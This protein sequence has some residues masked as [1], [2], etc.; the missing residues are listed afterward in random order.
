[1]SQ[2]ETLYKTR[3]PDRAQ[4]EF[5]EVVFSARPADCPQLF[6][7]TETHGWWDDKSR[8]LI[9]E[10]RTLNPDEALSFE[11]AQKM[12][13]ECRSNRAR[14]GFVHSFTRNHMGEEEYQHLQIE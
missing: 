4:S 6:G 3:T 1:M 2:G 12:Y 11:D 8:R 9:H 5:Y 13:F 10:V 7:V 14:G